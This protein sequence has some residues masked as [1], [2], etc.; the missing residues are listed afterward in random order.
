M[1]K[2][3]ES[4]CIFLDR[5]G[6]L[7]HDLGTYLFRPEDL[8]I[9]ADVASALKLLKEAGYLLIVITNQAGIAKGLY[10]RDAVLEIHR[11]IQEQTG[12]QFD[13]LY[14]SPYHQDFTQSLSRKPGTLMLEKAIAKHK[15]LVEKSWMIGDQVRDIM[16]GK[17]AGLKT[18]LINKEQTAEKA[19][20]STTSLLEAANII[21][22][23]VN[24]NYQTF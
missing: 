23:A 3:P 11:L 18:I 1:F 6:V 20:F 19:D 10:T 2:A 22:S 13:D 9:P 21:L 16:A 17:N 12:I 15:V 4:P 8:V 14:F 7:N 5:D 24:G